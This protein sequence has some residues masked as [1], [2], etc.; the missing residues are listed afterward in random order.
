MPTWLPLVNSMETFT[1]KIACVIIT[2]RDLE[3]DFGIR[4]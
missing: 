4:H 2:L 1:E 3:P